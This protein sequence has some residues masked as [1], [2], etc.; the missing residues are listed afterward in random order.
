[1]HHA[2]NVISSAPLNITTPAG[3][4]AVLVGPNLLHEL[5][6]LLQ[7]LGLSGKLW[8]ISDGAVY[9]HHGAAVEGLLRD[10]GYRVESYTVPPGEASKDLAVVAKL[11]D[12]MIGG[13]VERREAVLALGA[14]VVG[15]LAG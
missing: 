2:E 14:G 13:A 15:D 8:L 12:W 5:P 9:P 10:A 4:Y 7:A 6:A 11:Y 3:S 1:M